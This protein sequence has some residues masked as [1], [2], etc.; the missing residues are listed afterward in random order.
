MTAKDYLR[1][2]YKMDRRLRVL[3]GKVD[4]LRSSL[5]YRSPSLESSGGGSSADRLPDALAKIMEYEQRADEL[6]RQYID[7]Y[8]EIDG[9]IRSVQNA[10]QREVLE[11]RYLLYQK[12]ETIA[13]EMNYS[14]QN[15]YK[16]H[17]KGLQKIILK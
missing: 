7:K 16:L 13:E 15:V 6:R 14:L 5:D 2:A 11:R 8:I 9:T 10:T 4:E 12:W 1:Q 3:Q 17:G